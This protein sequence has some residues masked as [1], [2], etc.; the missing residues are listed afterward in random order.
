MN[1]Q[2]ITAER[3]QTI[4]EAAQS[5][6]I[7]IPML[8]N[9]PSLD[10]VSACRICL[11]EIE[12]LKVL[13]PACSTK[14]TD[15]IVV[16]TE[17]AKVVE[18][19][20]FVLEL[21]FAE[22]NHYCM[23]CQMSGDCELQTLGYRYGLDS[24]MYPR[25]YPKLPVDATRLYFVMDHNRCILCRRCVRACGDLVGNY[26]L[27]LGGRGADTLIIADLNVPFGDSSCISCGTC[28]QVCPTGALMDRQSAYRGIE[29]QVD[30]IKSTCAACSV[31]CG[32][33]LIARDNQLLRVEGD[34][35]AEV[36]KGLLCVAG[37]FEPLWD[38]RRR[39]YRPMVR[40][41]GKLEEATWDEALDAAVD[42]LKAVN[43][44]SLAALASP[45]TTNEALSLFAELFGGLGAKSISNLKPVP[46]FLVG[47]EGS[48]A[49]L[50]EADLFV[51]VGEDLSVDHQVAGMAVRRGLMNR[52]ARLV[53]ISEDENGM[54]DFAQYSFKPDQVDKAIALAKRAASPAIVYGALAGDLVSVLQD[55]LSGQAQF[56]GL[57][58]GSNARGALAAGLNGA[59]KADGVKG[60]FVLVGDDKVN[61]SLLSDL[62]NVEFIIAQTSYQGSLVE[63]A[64]IVLPTAIW[65]E[66][67]GTS[68]NTEGRTQTL[69]AALKPPTGVKDDRQILQALAERLG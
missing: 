51:V 9:H 20:R 68:T 66:K 57:V 4:L 29:T 60:V 37:H 48:L 21:L 44:A 17:S 55:E 13:Q 23:Y 11:V 45:R 18:T 69:Q 41:N 47:V 35:D 16:H 40:R 63:R 54:A 58:S 33:E 14:V 7:D 6:G 36:N 27:G 56:V 24:W 46:E 25:P 8:C 65:V 28:L 31:G 53:L 39:V 42:K 5:V 15:G 12:K 38:N 2:E 67:S 30:R 3:G 26:T 10:P 64:D 49:A 61:G 34:W 50:D 59:F 19:R 43:G 52:G 22:R 32:V 1:G 62:E